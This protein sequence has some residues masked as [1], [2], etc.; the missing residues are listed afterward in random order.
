MQSEKSK[1]P[2]SD[3]SSQA[4]VHFYLT[5]GRCD[6]YNRLRSE[7]LQQAQSS[8][9][10]VPLTLS[11]HLTPPLITFRQL[12]TFRVL[13]RH[14]PVHTRGQNSG[15]LC[16]EACTWFRPARLLRD[17]EGWGCRE[18][19]GRGGALTDVSDDGDVTG[20]WR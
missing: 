6:T 19:K 10:S 2:N 14:H 13:S 1:N 15:A 8:P 16:I 12:V 5:S 7:A 20:G 11:R 3:N 17:R 9:I 18:G 4:K